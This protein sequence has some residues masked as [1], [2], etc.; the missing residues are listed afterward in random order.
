[1]SLLTRINRSYGLQT[2]S[3]VSLEVGR[4]YFCACCMFGD[5]LTSF[6]CDLEIHLLGG[7]LIFAHRRMEAPFG[8]YA[9]R[10][11]RQVR[12]HR[13]EDLQGSWLAV[14]A[15]PAV[16]PYC[17]GFIRLCLRLRRRSTIGDKRDETRGTHCRS[18]RPGDSRSTPAGNRSEEHTSELQSPTYLVCRLL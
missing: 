14:L 6:E 7:G 8:N 12:A 18:S 16:Q 4:V 9:Q 10:L 11:F 13:V 3:I 5:D 1:M 15:D 2:D 17:D